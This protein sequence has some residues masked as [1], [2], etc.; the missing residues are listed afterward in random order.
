[1]LFGMH[2]W[3]TYGVIGTRLDEIRRRNRTEF[4]KPSKN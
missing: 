1:M 3:D 4:D 2:L